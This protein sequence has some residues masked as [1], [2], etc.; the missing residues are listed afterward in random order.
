M[1]FESLAATNLEVSTIHRQFVSSLMDQRVH[2][3][4]VYGR[5]MSLIES[6]VTSSLSADAL[7]LPTTNDAVWIWIVGD[8]I[9]ICLMKKT[10]SVIMITS[11]ELA[12]MMQKIAECL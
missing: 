6:F 5:G 9:V 11:H 4:G 7:D 3:A 8:M 1:T 2:I 10:P 12:T